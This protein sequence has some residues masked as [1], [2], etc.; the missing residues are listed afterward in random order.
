MTI[1]LDSI[2]SVKSSERMVTMMRRASE[3]S[4]DGQSDVPNEFVTQRMIAL[5]NDIRVE[6]LLSDID[7]RND[8]NVFAHN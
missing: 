8:M 6:R 2:E 4:G 3:A 7:E 5:S 1:D